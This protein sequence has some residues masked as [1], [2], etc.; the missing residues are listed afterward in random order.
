MGW[1]SVDDNFADHRKIER[2]SDAAFRLHVAGLCMTAR[3]QDDGLVYATKVPRLVPRF[4]KNALQELIDAGIW[5]PHPDGYEIHDYLD[6]NL[7]RAQIEAR[8]EKKR[9]AGKK[10][11]DAKWHK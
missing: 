3:M 6:W 7:S 10:G 11:A 8:R 9:E 4:R 5:I 2:L 1:L